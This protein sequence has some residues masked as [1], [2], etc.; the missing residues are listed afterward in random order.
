MRRRVLSAYS[1]IYANLSAVPLDHLQSVSN[2]GARLIFEVSRLE[3]KTLLLR[4][5]LHWLRC[6]E[7]IQ[8]KPY[9]SIYN[10]VNSMVPSFIKELCVPGTVTECCAMLQ[11]AVSN[12]GR[13][14][15]PF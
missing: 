13:L 1:L 5:F 6:P 8:F 7:G 11:L 14:T 12:T 10:A 15:F 4:D 3:H 2:V 9:V